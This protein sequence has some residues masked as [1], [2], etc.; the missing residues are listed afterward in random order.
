MATEEK[1]I[2]EIKNREKQVNVYILKIYQ[3]L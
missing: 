1:T 3:Y 2:E